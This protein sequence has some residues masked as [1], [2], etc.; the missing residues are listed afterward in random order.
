VTTSW[1]CLDER[2][3]L[4]L[5]RAALE[6]AI[7]VVAGRAETLASEMESGTIA[8][9]GGAEALRL[10]ATLT[11]CASITADAI[12]SQIAHGQAGHA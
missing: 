9:Q 1:E 3:Q 2:N 4:A 7:G 5:A 10:F 6:R 12:Y 11:R 8:D